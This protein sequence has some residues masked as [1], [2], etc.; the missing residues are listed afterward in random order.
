M[1]HFIFF[2]KKNNNQVFVMLSNKDLVGV[3]WSY[4]LIPT[5]DEEKLDW[6]CKADSTLPY[7]NIFDSYVY[8]VKTSCQ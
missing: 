8:W 2:Q 7:M 4:L 3:K 5:L 6:G 1:G